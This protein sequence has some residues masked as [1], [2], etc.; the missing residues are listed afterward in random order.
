MVYN[1][2]IN[3]Q[4]QQKSNTYYQVMFLKRDLKQNCHAGYAYACWQKLLHILI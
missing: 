3:Q 4:N 2:K 1:K